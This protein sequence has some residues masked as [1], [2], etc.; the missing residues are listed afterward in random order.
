M[1]LAIITPTRKRWHWLL[2]QAR[3]LA[4]QMRAGDCWVVVV[5]N[6]EPNEKAIDQVTR[7]VGQERLTWAML[8]YLRPCVPAACVNRCHNLG[9]ALAPAAADLVEIDDHDLIEPCALDEIRLALANDCDYVFG[10]HRQ[11]ALLAGPNG[12][13]YLETWPD[14]RHAYVRGGFE[15]GE[16]D[17]IGPRAI[18]RSLWNKLSGWDLDVWPCGDK[19]FA[20][21]AERAGAAIVCLELPLATVTIDPE[22]LSAAFRGRA[23]QEV[24]R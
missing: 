12:R 24:S 2:E 3:A 13:D 7:L 15:R 22:S 8:S 1:P 23:P 10:W 14:V 9:A 6:D 20:L 16:I 17:A 19:D 21:R 4:P 18:R 5:D 11:Q